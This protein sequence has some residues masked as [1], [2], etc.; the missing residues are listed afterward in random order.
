MPMDLLSS[1]MSSV[2]IETTGIVMMRLSA[3]WGLLVEK[4]P[5]ASLFALTEGTC[6][7]RSAQGERIVLEAGDV[8]LLSHNQDGEVASDA[9]APLARLGDVFAANELPI[10]RPGRAPGAPLRLEHGGGGE[11]AM[12]L[13]LLFGFRE[14]LSQTYFSVL[15]DLLVL[16]RDDYRMFPWIQMT[17][18][19]LMSEAEQPGEGY[20]AVASRLAELLFVYIVRAH[21][22]LHPEQTSGWLRGASDRRIARALG[23]MHE[24]MAEPWTVASLASLAGMSRST[25]AATF[26]ALVGQPPLDYLLQRRMEAATQRLEAGETSLPRLAR[27]L[28]YSSQHS[29]TVAF[30]RVIGM[31]PA[32]YRRA[33]A[34]ER[35][36]REAHAP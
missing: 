34:E 8:V 21:L 35:D 25:F 26:A 23:A 13:S 22:L 27:D 36:A 31:P 1:V 4:N 5:A 12:A 20:V 18:A 32:T 33:R 30:T 17:L 7:I 15:P 19:F 2:R 9:H 10:W 29:F 6:E 24:R 16:R 11:P 3:P 28:G 14:R